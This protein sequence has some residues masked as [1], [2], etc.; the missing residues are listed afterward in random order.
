MDE[1][2]CQ[3]SK[4]KK[5]ES[6]IVQF[7][8]FENVI[9]TVPHSVLEQSGTCKN[10]LEFF[11]QEAALFF[12][13]SSPVT[14]DNFQK[15]LPLLEALV[16]EDWNKIET[17]LETILDRYTLKECI[18]MLE[19]ADYL[20]VPLV[21]DTIFKH[22]TKQKFLSKETIALTLEK[23]CRLTPLLQESMREAVAERLHFLDE[24]T[25]PDTILTGYYSDLKLVRFSPNGK[26]IAVCSSNK[27]KLLDSKTGDCIH[28]LNGHNNQILAIDFSS[29][30]TL[31][32][33]N[34]DSEI[35]VWSSQ[36]GQC[37]QELVRD[38]HKVST[39]C[40]RT[41]GKTVASGSSDGTI[42]FWDIKTGMCIKKLAVGMGLDVLCFS[43]G[44]RLIASDS[45]DGMVQL[46]DVQTGVCIKTMHNPTH[47]ACLL[48]F[49]SDGMLLAS[50]SG[51]DTITWWNIKTGVRVDIVAY[52]LENVS[53]LCFSP[54]G[55][56]VVSGSYNGA[57]KLWD[58]TTGRCVQALMGRA[59][60]LSSICFSP[61]GKIL[62]SACEDGVI[63][64]C[65]VGSAK[66][67][68]KNLSVSHVVVLFALKN[69][70]ITLSDIYACA[71]LTDIFESIPFDI[72][73]QYCPRLSYTYKN[74]SLTLRRYMPGVM[75]VPFGVGLAVT[76]ACGLYELGYMIY[77][78]Q[79][80]IA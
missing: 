44:G 31:I 54:D 7:E 30:G 73:K 53:S 55:A 46:W 22:I 50:S 2:T 36:T 27:I 4:I 47:S 43:P 63:Q 60:W 35:R 52:H 45:D 26:L 13:A 79:K 49:S 66:A 33:T 75:L 24:Y 64:F 41:D 70:Y 8:G 20:N 42:Q 74:I 65:D 56:L 51:H 12:D 80:D 67:A 17:S 1:S 68:L 15:I 76:A 18:S 40:F 34:S 58:S 29:D 62:V 37:I 77:E 23:A 39:I 25:I 69:N 10:Q 59:D 19:I 48:C 71:Y 32:A 28:I 21:I 16:Q 9:V 72:Q 57:L 38:L 78:N 6:I 11:S 3:A 61:D 5:E 14:P